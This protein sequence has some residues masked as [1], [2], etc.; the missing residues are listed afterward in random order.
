[1]VRFILRSEL[2]V[3]NSVCVASLNY[4]KGTKLPF[5]HGLH[6]MLRLVITISYFLYFLDFLPLW[7]FCVR[8]R[9]WFWPYDQLMLRGVGPACCFCLQ[10]WHLALQSSS[11]LDT[12]GPPTSRESNKSPDYQQK[13]P[14]TVGTARPCPLHCLLPINDGIAT[15]P[16]TY[17]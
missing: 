6:H 3:S 2:L 12:H 14:R 16:R 13:D 10:P 17:V 1:M 9:Y 11:Q 5:G 15:L 7:R 8:R 4:W